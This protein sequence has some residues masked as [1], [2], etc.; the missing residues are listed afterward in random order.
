MGRRINIIDLRYFGRENYTYSG[1]TSR[2][3]GTAHPAGQRA[4]YATRK[5]QPRQEIALGA[6]M[7]PLSRAATIKASVIMTTKGR[8]LDAPAT[9]DL[10]GEIS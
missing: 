10:V 4:L 5:S 6:I 7:R 1:D 2:G 3:I 9:A 8:K